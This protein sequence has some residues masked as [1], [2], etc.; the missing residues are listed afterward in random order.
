MLRIS[1][2]I[3]TLAFTAT[4]LCREPKVVTVTVEDTYVIPSSETPQQAKENA[5][6]K[7]Q[8]KGIADK[9][10]STISGSNQLSIGLSGQGGTA[11]SLRVYEVDEVNGEWIQ[12]LDEQ[13]K[14]YTDPSTGMLVYKVK[15]KGKVRELI[16]NRIPVEWSLLINGTDIVKNRLREPTYYVGDYMYLYFQSPVDGYL[17]VYLEDNDESHTTQCLIPYRGMSEGA[18]KIEANK[19]YIFF[20][21]EDA[22][23]EIR[24]KVARIK[25]DSHYELDYNQLHIIFSPNEFWKSADYD[26][27][28]V[29]R[30]IKDRDNNAIHLMPRQLV[31]KTF[32]TW[33]AKNR[34]RDI[35]MQVFHI[36]LTIRL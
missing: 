5:V 11:E 10:G 3:I 33:L 19:P 31:G 23:P 7:A 16:Q 8:L 13:V 34:L 4:A 15:L 29:G 24:S 26:N 22:D 2:F 12:T 27:T 36:D 14:P 9:F 28:D 17:T 32:H 1:L 18:F 21:K 30:V 20:S 6:R 25:M 35:D